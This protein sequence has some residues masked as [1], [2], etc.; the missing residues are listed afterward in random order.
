MNRK[1]ILPILIVSL[2]LFGCQ[3]KYSDNNTSE[4]HSLEFNYD[5]QNGTDGWMGGLAGIDGDTLT[6]GFDINFAQADYS[7]N[8]N[9]NRGIYL[10][11]S[12]KNNNMFMYTT[13]K[14]SSRD[15]LSPLSNYEVNLKFDILPVKN[16]N[17]SIPMDRLFIKA[18][19][20]NIEPSMQVIER[21]YNNYL[22][23]NPNT[24]DASK[25]INLI[26]LGN[27]DAL[28]NNDIETFQ[29]SFNATTNSNGEMWV[30]IGVDSDYKGNGSL[31]LDNVNISINKI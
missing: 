8:D 29:E 17:N 30:I 24:E 20:V 16:N 15:G 7:L 1:I 2:L 11:C 28:N 4:S 3:N 6:Y 5:F 26:T 25:K 21:G 10:T 31:F 14:L 9:S 18:A 22:F 19:V 27:A 13:K 23:V 12:T